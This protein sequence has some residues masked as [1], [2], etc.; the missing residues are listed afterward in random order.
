M[1]GHSVSIDGDRC[2][3]NGIQNACDVW[4]NKAGHPAD[5]DKESMADSIVSNIFGLSTAQRKLPTPKVKLRFG[6][7]GLQH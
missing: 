5:L 7:R 2:T 3:E 4:V 1:T 6:S